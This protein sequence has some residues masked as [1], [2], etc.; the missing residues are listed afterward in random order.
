MSPWVRTWVAVHCT[1]SPG[2]SVAVE[3]AAVLGDRQVAEDDVMEGD[4]AGVGDV[5]GV[6]DGVA[7]VGPAGR[8]RARRCGGCRSCRG[9]SSRPAGR[10]PSALSVS[11]TVSPWGAVA[12]TSAVLST[13]PASMSAWVR[14]WVAVQVAVSPGSSVAAAA[15]QVSVTDGS[16]DDDA[17]E[18][19]VAGVLEGEAVA[20]DVAGVATA[21]EAE[22]ER[23]RLVDRDRPDLRHEDGGGGRVGRVVAGAGGPERAVG[24]GRGA[25]GDRAGVDV[26]LAD[27]VGGSCTSR[28][29]RDRAC[30]RR[31]CH[32]RCRRRA[33]W[34][35]VRTGA[36][37]VTLP[38]LLDVEGVA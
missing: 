14:A 35:S 2:S 10:R 5:E 36:V 26:G 16:R 31:R 7:G 21:V 30:C 25:V 4:V 27:G 32:R 1:V 28:S 19:H 13:W 22:I 11:L 33:Q 34:S 3:G 29:P 15:G 37:R 24:V 12:S 23:A 6:G 17:V 8:A 20:D 18:G 9:R 38:V